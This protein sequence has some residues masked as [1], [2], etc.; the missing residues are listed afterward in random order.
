MKDIMDL[1][2]DYIKIHPLST[3]L[4]SE[5]ISQNDKAQQDALELIYKIFDYLCGV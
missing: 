5:Y 4:G 2:E 3:E 1:I